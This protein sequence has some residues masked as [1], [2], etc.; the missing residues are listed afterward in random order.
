VALGELRDAGAVPALIDLL[1]HHDPRVT[2]SA[3]RALLAITK[4]DFGR[5]QR[6]WRAWWERNRSRHRIEWMLAGLAHRTPE[7]RLS[8]SEELRRLTQEY[9]GYHFDLP[10][11]EREEA[12]KRWVAWWESAGRTRFGA[13]PDGRARGSEV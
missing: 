6:R 9:F 3:H 10:R 2:S 12:R 11:R 7:V 13:D 8:A 1:D 4:Q 5:R